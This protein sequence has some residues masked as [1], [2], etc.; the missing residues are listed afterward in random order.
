M[1]CE[2]DEK[3][4]GHFRWAEPNAVAEGGRRAAERGAEDEKRNGN[5]GRD[6]I[7]YHVIESTFSETGTKF[8]K[9]PSLF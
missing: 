3:S 4:W 2:G 5:R 7:I 9:L 1:T 8:S 6:G